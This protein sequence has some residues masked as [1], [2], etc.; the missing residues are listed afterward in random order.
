MIDDYPSPQITMSGGELEQIRD[1]LGDLEARLQDIEDREAIVNLIVD[2]ARAC[3]QGNDPKLLDPLFT[4]DAVWECEGFGRY[5][6]RARLCSALQGI[7]GEKI[8]WSL[9]YMIS[10]RIEIDANNDRAT[11]F[12]YLWESATIPDS[13]TDK[14]EPHW[15]GATYDAIVVKQAGRWLFQSMQLN[16]SMVSPCSD[17]WVKRP[18]PVGGVRLPYF[19]RT[20]PGTYAWC[21]CGRSNK[22][23]YCDGSHRETAIQPHSFRVDSE[24][25]LALCGCKRTATPPYCDGTHLNLD[26]D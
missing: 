11:A 23:P 26:I 16:L 17:G 12:W 10:P 2:Y 19:Q 9:H 18:F 1:R 25:L 6:G 3:D 14:P 5:E 24:K 4:E 8:W 15:I 21:A 20:E 22:Q 13:A 7:A